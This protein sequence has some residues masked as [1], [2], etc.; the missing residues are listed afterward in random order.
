MNKS[1]VDRDML[2]SSEMQENMN[3]HIWYIIK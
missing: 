2:L 3:F 1:N